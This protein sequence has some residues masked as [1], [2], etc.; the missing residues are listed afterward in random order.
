MTPIVFKLFSIAVVCATVST[1]DANPETIQ[2]SVFAS[3]ERI[4]LKSSLP[5]KL[6]LREPTTARVLSILHSKSLPL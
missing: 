4:F 6:A 2:I 5:C 3:P 1:P